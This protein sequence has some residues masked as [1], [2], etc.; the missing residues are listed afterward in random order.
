MV[1]YHKGDLLKSDCNVICHQVNLQGVMGGGIAKQISEKYPDCEKAYNDYSKNYGDQN[2]R[3]TVYMCKV[4]EKKWIANC[5]SQSLFYDT[6]YDWVK[7]CFNSVKDFAEQNNYSV[8]LPYKYGCG[9]AHGDW[10]IVSNIIEEVF[11]NSKIDC[12]VWEYKKG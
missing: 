3:S 6:V 8:G 12:Q 1:S 4:G 9:I 5:Y 7:K 11:G 10:N 2:T